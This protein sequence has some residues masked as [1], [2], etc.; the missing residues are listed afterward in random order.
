M[1]L[2]PRSSAH[3]PTALGQAVLLY[4]IRVAV[5]FEPPNKYTKD[6]SPWQ[7]VLHV[8]CLASNNP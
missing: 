6:D 2:A 1:L 4:A 7:P 3:C 5:L 8:T